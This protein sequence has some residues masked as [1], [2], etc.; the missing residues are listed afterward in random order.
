MRDIRIR[1][2]II[3][4]ILYVLSFPFLADISFSSNQPDEAITRAQAETSQIG[5]PKQA[6]TTRQQF[7]VR[8]KKGASAN[9]LP[10]SVIA[11]LGIQESKK[12]EG[13]KGAELITLLPGSDMKKAL[14]YFTADPNVLYTKPSYDRN[15]P[16]L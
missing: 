7:I 15:L 12:I 4:A 3:I 16:K 6:Q 13:K 10:V 9:A 11:V 2:L 8:F 14:S 1:R 5:E